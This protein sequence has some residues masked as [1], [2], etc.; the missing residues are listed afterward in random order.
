MMSNAK[1]EAGGS[2]GNAIGVAVVGENQ[3][4][5]SAFKQAAGNR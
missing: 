5:S 3:G 2:G 1:N 4:C